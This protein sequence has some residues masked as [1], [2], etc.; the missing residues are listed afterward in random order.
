MYTPEARKKRT[1]T[2]AAV[3]AAAAA[4]EIRSLLLDPTSE[5]FIGLEALTCT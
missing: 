5:A 1:T 2:V 4:G 3:A